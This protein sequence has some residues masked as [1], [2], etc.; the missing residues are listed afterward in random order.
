MDGIVAAA[1]GIALDHDNT[2]ALSLSRSLSYHQRRRVTLDSAGTVVE[3]AALGVITAKNGALSISS[4]G[5]AKLQAAN[6]VGS[7]SIAN[8][9]AGTV[10]YRETGGLTVA[11]ASNGASGA[12][13]LIDTAGVLDIAGRGQRRQG[14]PLTSAGGL[15]E[16]GSGAITATT[17]TGSAAGA[18]ALGGSN[19]IVTLAGFTDTVGAFS[20]TNG[21]ALKQAGTLNV[22]TN[23]AALTATAGNIAVNGTIEASTLTLDSQAGDLTESGSLGAIKVGTLNATAATGIILTGTHNAITTIG[24]DNP[25]TGPN[26]IT[27]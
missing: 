7:L 13:T 9:G 3:A 23:D 16:T 12:L 22:G 25:G 19:K 14:H 5:G 18:V 27:Q 2:R 15:E 11:S 17:L 4:V 26:K 6:Q 24:I 21:E 10:S 1:D 8:T 20:L